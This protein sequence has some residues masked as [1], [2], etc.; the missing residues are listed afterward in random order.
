M[1]LHT[2]YAMRQ[3]AGAARANVSGCSH[4][5]QRGSAQVPAFERTHLPDALDD[6]ANGQGIAGGEDR[7]PPLRESIEIAL[8]ED[9]TEATKTCDLRARFDGAGCRPAY[10]CSVVEQIGVCETVGRDKGIDIKTTRF[11]AGDGCNFDV[12]DRPGRDPGQDV[13]DLVIRQRRTLG[14]T[15]N[16]EYIGSRT[17]TFLVPYQGKIDLG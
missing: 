1:E 10:A 6:E 2:L 8:D 11:R 17:P 7:T 14:P 9:G 3:T 15:K 13:P 12:T 4:D 5:E 16:R